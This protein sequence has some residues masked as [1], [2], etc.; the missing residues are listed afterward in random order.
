VDAANANELPEGT[1]PERPSYS[2]AD[3]PAS[4]TEAL[5]EKRG[6]CTAWTP[7]DVLIS[8]LRGIDS[9]TIQATDL[10]VV[11]ST[12]SNDVGVAQSCRDS[13]VLGGML[14]YAATKSCDDD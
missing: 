8:V 2:F 14:L 9:G 6:D 1:A 12:G 7:R 11:Y 10:V 5:A 3:Y 13:R 4:V